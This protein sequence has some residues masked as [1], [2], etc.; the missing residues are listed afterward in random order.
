MELEG[1]KEAGE[2]ELELP[3]RLPDS[4]RLILLS[5]AFLP[6]FAL[7]DSNKRPRFRRNEKKASPQLQTEDEKEGRR[8]KDAL[9]YP[10][11]IPKTARTMPPKIIPS[12]TECTRGAHPVVETVVE[13]AAG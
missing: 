13:E 1:G 5:M 7:R 12:P 9:I 4:R 6:H 10:L 2:H 11:S 8:L 3:R